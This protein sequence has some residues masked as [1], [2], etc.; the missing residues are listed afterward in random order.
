MADNDKKPVPND[1]DK[2]SFAERKA[3]ATWLFDPETSVADIAYCFD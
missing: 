3:E 2:P 1:S